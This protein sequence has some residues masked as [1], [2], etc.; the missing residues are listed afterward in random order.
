MALNVDRDRPNH[1]GSAPPGLRRTTDPIRRARMAGDVLRDRDGA[2]GDQ[3]VRVGLGADTVACRATCSV[4]R[5]R[6][7]RH[8]ATCT[9]S[10][11]SARRWRRPSTTLA[12]V[13]PDGGDLDG[14]ATCVALVVLSDKAGAVGDCQCDCFRLLEADLKIQSETR[15]AVRA[16]QTLFEKSANVAG[17]AT[18]GRC[19]G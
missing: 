10:V 8:L 5:A 2:L 1:R 14:A 7:Q 6:C 15:V 13:T 17:R 19:H 4:R 3:R 12:D 18:R 11:R 16:R 9:S